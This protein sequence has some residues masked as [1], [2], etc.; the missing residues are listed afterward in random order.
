M[1]TQYE[2]NHPICAKCM[3]ATHLKEFMEEYQEFISFLEHKDL[4]LI[5][6]HARGYCHGQLTLANDVVNDLAALLPRLRIETKLRA[7]S[8]KG[9]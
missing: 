9:L 2:R 6:T 4:N 7:K 5:S 8:D 1:K 3:V